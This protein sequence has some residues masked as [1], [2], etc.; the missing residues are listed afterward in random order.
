[1]F[2]SNEAPGYKSGIIA[3]LCAFCINLTLNQVLRIIYMR[4]NKRRDN[5]LQGR[6]EQEVADLKRQGELQGF[7]DVTDKHNV[8]VHECS[9]HSL[10]YIL[11]LTEVISSRPCFGMRCSATGS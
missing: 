1:M 3:M 6:T 4:E 10:R 2:K 11:I 8:S 5:T 7:E 9:G